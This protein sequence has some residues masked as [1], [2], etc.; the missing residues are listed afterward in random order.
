MQSTAAIGTQHDAQPLAHSTMQDDHRFGKRQ[1]STS[2]TISACERNAGSTIHG[3]CQIDASR[4]ASRPIKPSAAPK[5]R[6]KTSAE[7]SI[8]PGS[9]AWK[10][11][12]PSPEWTD[13]SRP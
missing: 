10:R 9:P 12:L 7:R 3:H 6:G 2:C 13:R 1:A 5:E 8:S 4:H 11:S